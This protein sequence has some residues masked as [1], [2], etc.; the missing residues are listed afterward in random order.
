LIAELA[1]LVNLFR[2]LFE[3]IVSA[4][5]RKHNQPKLELIDRFHLGDQ[6]VKSAGTVRLFLQ[7]TGK[8]AA[9]DILVKL[10]VVKPR[11]AYPG[12][13]LFFNEDIGSLESYKKP[14]FLETDRWLKPEIYDFRLKPDIFVNPGL[15][16]ALE[17]AR[18]IVFAV[19]D[20][21]PADLDHKVEW[22]IHCADNP[23]TT[24]L[25][26]REGI[27]LK[28]QLLKNE[29]ESGHV[30][31]YEIPSGKLPEPSKDDSE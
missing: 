6:G 17:I 12:Y 21:P 8:A 28:R 24:G 15:Q 30:I 16:A 10:K 7:N 29:Y 13:K 5:R 25:I 14:G 2:S 22:T 23:L 9:K 4:L 3:F 27:D 11:D 31:G 18:F 20:T 26:M 1:S 19:E